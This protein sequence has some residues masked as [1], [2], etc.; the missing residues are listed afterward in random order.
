LRHAH[1]SESER[2][3]ALRPRQQSKRHNQRDTIFDA[4]WGPEY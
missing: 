4:F 2:M 3:I 1:G